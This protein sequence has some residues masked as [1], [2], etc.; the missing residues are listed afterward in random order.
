MAFSALGVAT[1]A[2]YH[3][4][5][6]LIGEEVEFTNQHSVEERT[7]ESPI[8]ALRREVHEDAAAGNNNTSGARTW[9][10]A[11]SLRSN[12]SHLPFGPFF[13]LPASYLELLSSIE[14]RP[15]AK[16]TP[17]KAKTVK[18]SPLKKAKA[19]LKKAPLKKAPLKKAPLKK[20]PLKKAPLKKAPV[21]KAPV[22]KAPVK[23]APVKKGQFEQASECDV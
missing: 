19:P 7:W 4:D 1:A 16:R 22:K 9:D 10:V 8:K 20:A 11:W 5:A 13:L 2:G 6:D 12:P 3:T 15:R 23:K 14:V 17:A 21:K 18:K